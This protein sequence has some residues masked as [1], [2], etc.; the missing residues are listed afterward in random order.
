MLRLLTA[1]SGCRPTYEF[2]IGPTASPSEVRRVE[3][4]SGETL[5][6]K[7][8]NIWQT[9]SISRDIWGFFS[10]SFIPPA[11]PVITSLK[12]AGSPSGRLPRALL[13]SFP[14][15]LCCRPGLLISISPVHH[16]LAARYL[17]FCFSLNQRL[18]ADPFQLLMLFTR[19]TCGNSKRELSCDAK[20]CNTSQLVLSVN[21]GGPAVYVFI[22]SDEAICQILWSW[23]LPRG[24]RVQRRWNKTR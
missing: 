14:H 10:I 3:T 15:S 2:L 9:A 20:C 11:G 1:C 5:K 18:S 17:L 6:N 21:E 19:R 22:F 23:R 4:A 16:V 12:P 13:I 24:H 8:E 7:N